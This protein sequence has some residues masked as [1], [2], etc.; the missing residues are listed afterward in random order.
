[1]QVLIRKS[2]YGLSRMENSMT[3]K[4]VIMTIGLEMS[5]GAIIL[6][7]YMILWLVAQKIIKLKSG[8]VLEKINGSLKLKSIFKLPLGK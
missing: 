2:N 7:F 8:N 6:D 5:H 1:M 4:L 3:K